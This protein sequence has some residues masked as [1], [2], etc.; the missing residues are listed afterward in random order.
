MLYAGVE[1]NRKT[2]DTTTWLHAVAYK[3][4]KTPPFYPQEFKSWTDAVLQHIGMTQEHITAQ[5]C[6]TV[7][8]K[9]IQYSDV[10]G[11]Y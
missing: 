6:R 3:S 5:N 11:L 10:C 4:K 8:L 2:V 9:L 1:D 7:Y